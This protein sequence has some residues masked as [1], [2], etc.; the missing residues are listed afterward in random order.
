MERGLGEATEARE[1]SSALCPVS[2]SLEASSLEK[3]TSRPLAFPQGSGW[4]GP[5]T[6]LLGQPPNLLQGLCDTGQLNS[7]S[8][9]QSPPPDGAMSLPVTWRLQLSAGVGVPE[10][11]SSPASGVSM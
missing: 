7:S 3:Q 10:G 11:C 4:L 8:R 9:Q 5:D 1:G 2:Q 6:G